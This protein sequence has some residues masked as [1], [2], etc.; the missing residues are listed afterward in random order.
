MPLLEIVA[1]Q[2]DS[3][4][5]RCTVPGGANLQGAGVAA[6]AQ[7][8]SWGSLGWMHCIVP[9][10]FSWAENAPAACECWWSRISR[11]GRPGLLKCIVPNQP[12]N[13][14]PQVGLPDCFPDE[15]QE[16]TRHP[17]SAC[18]SPFQTNKQEAI[19]KIRIRVSAR[20]VLDGLS[21]R[22]SDRG[23]ESTRL[24]PP[25]GKGLKSFSCQQGF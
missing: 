24:Q 6:T 8:K 18:P 25:N 19:G 9:W 13:R 11:G 22:R 4:R 7:G 10:L 3:A 12:W 2:R 17:L 15:T 5:S 16:V 1:M 21:S 20:A 23:R 14:A